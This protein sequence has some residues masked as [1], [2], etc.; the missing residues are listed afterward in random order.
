MESPGHCT[1]L[2]GSCSSRSPAQ[3]E[4]PRGGAARVALQLR[5]RRLTPTSLTWVKHVLLQSD[6]LVHS[7]QGP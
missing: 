7:L 3:A 4:L 6:Q 2:Q 1:V 5:K